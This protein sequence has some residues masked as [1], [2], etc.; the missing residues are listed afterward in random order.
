MLWKVFYLYYTCERDIRSFARVP[1]TV[2]RSNGRR[3]K[4]IVGI[5]LWMYCKYTRLLGTYYEKCRNVGTTTEP[6]YVNIIRYTGIVV[7]K[8]LSNPYREY[9]YLYLY[10]AFVSYEP[11]LNNTSMIDER[12]RGVTTDTHYYTHRCEYCA[13]VRTTTCYKNITIR[14]R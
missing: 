14:R 6:T 1:R 8:G 5:L 7:M 2:L 3:T 13:R 4:Y 11:R 9:L 10:W 12:D